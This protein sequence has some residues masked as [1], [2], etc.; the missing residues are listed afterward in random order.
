MDRKLLIALGHQMAN[1]LKQAIHISEE[2]PDLGFT[3]EVVM[4]LT[5]ALQYVQEAC[6]NSP[7]E[8]R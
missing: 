3:M 5:N 4:P 1:S 7:Q 6:Q 8:D 2:S